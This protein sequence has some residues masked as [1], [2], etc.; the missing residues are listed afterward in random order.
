M[1]RTLSVLWLCFCVTRTTALEATATAVPKP[2]LRQS[3]L[4]ASVATNAGTTAV[5]DKSVVTPVGLV[6]VEVAPQS[7]RRRLD[8]LFKRPTVSKIAINVFL[9]WTLNVVFSLCN[10]Q[11]LNSWPHPW[12]LACS[13]LAIG[14]LCMLPLYIPLPKRSASGA[15]EWVPTRQV[16]RLTKAELHTLLPVAA[17]LS[18][19]HVT[20]T[21][22]PAYGTVAFS[23]IV[24]TAEPL[25]TCACSMV[26]YRRLYSTPVYLALLMV[27]SGVALV[28]CRDVNFSSFSL[29]AGMISNAAFA[30][31]SIYAKRAM[32]AHPEVLTPRTAYALLTMGSL[33][34]L[35]PLAL[36]M[37][38]SGAGASRL[39]SA[40]TAVGTLRT[41]WRLAALLGFTGLVQYVSNEIAFC[42]LSMIHPV[43]YAVANTLKRSIVVASSLVFFQQSLPATGY[44]G[45]FMAIAGAFIYSVY[46]VAP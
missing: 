29:M 39:A 8:A 4:L 15:R 30:L 33:T 44:A 16:P 26:L 38:W 24:K 34:M 27:V 6:E 21:L 5:V 7:R 14:T 28:S 37:E 36:L 9:W 46:S 22:A 41:G 3:V 31:Y 11:C 32:Q 20:S 1:A 25:F 23:N 13:H 19:G 35:T 18:V 43:T 17:L 42:T 2:L 12:A 10:K 40:S 45:A